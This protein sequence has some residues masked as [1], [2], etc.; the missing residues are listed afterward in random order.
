MKNLI[1]FLLLFFPAL[2]FAQTFYVE[3]TEFEYEKKVSEQLR[4]D[5]YKLTQ[6]RQ[7]A[8]FKVE[9]FATGQYN[10]WKMKDMFKG[11]LKI[12][13]AK[14]G[15]ELARTKEIGANAYN[16]KQAGNKIMAQINKKYL[17]ELIKT[18]PKP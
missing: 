16:I 11:Y 17:P 1:L 18:L 3:P 4:F 13:D 15:V 14:T 10:T 9:C 6:D 8:D 7:S 12:S 2:S 5:G